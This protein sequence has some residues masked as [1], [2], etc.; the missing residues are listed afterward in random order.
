MSEKLKAILAAIVIVACIAALTACAVFHVDGAAAALIGVVGVIVA[1]V[2]RQPAD[3]KEPPSGAMI[4]PFLA[5][6]A[7]IAA[8]L[9]LGCAEIGAALAEARYTE[10]LERCVEEE[11]ALPRDAPREKRAA[12]HARVDHCKGVVRERWGVA[13]TVTVAKDGGL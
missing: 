3:R 7:V 12:A 5:A 11:P 13:E 4:V 2:T 6:G 9:S 1:W 8:A 10:Q